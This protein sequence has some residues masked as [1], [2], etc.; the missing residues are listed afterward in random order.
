MDCGFIESAF[1][2]MNF[3]SIKH[4]SESPSFRGAKKT[5]SPKLLI[6]EALTI[7]LQ[8]C[9]NTGFSCMNIYRGKLGAEVDLLYVDRVENKR[10][11]V[12][13]SGLR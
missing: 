2:R 12:G 11:N 7:L 8:S 5:S 9:K 10:A 3:S 1:V 13:A 6:V 4:H